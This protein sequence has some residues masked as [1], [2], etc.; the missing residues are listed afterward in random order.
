MKINSYENA[1]FKVLEFVSYVVGS[2]LRTENIMY[3]IY[4]VKIR[5]HTQK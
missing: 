2:S 4:G 5:I 3:R 1:S